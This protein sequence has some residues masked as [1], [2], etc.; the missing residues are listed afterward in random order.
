[1]RSSATRASWSAHFQKDRK[2]GREREREG[3]RERKRVSECTT[4]LKL[5]I[6]A[7][8]RRMH[9]DLPASHGTERA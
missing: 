9:H 8:L 6:T 2:Y 3:E 7:V 5:N 1:M 4:A